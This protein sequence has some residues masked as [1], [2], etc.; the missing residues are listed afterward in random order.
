MKKIILSSIL[1]LGGIVFVG[2]NSVNAKEAETASEGRDLY[3]EVRAK[4]KGFGGS[5]CSCS[6]FKGYKKAGSN[7]FYGNC[8][9]R[10][11]G[12]VCGH[13]ASAHGL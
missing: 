3:V 9:N 5:L 1:V 12:H 11:N 10:V 13:S 2:L 4:C 8:Q 7:R 6:V